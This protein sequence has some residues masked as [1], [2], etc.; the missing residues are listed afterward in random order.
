MTLA[1]E[2]RQRG[3]KIDFHVRLYPRE[4]KLIDTLASKYDCSR[5]EII[6]AWTREY[7]DTD[8]SHKVKAGRRPGGGRKKKPEG[9]QHPPFPKGLVV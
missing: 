3:D 2:L 9:P 7:K 6:A 4:L 5:A 1:D 8:L